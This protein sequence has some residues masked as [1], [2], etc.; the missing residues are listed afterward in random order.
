MPIP[1]CPPTPHDP[2]LVRP[3]E[4]YAMAVAE[5]LL[6]RGIPLRNLDIGSNKDDPEFADVTA[7]IWLPTEYARALVDPELVEA[8]VDWNSLD[9]WSVWLNWGGL[10]DTTTCYMHGGLSPT[11]QQV[12]SFAATTLQDYQQAST[13]LPGSCATIYGA[14]T[15]C[16]W[17]PSAAPN[18][19]P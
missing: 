18:C 4:S 7:D 11:P 17:W 13:D 2:D 15:R 3:F 12:A 10:L 9:G 1:P 5:E 19:R 6:H 14:T 16:G 8:T